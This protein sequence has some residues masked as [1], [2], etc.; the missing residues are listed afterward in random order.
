MSFSVRFVT[1]EHYQSYILL[2]EIKDLHRV[3]PEC[4]ML[5]RLSR[6]PIHAVQNP[7]AP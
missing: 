5:W 4:P 3:R 2:T 6:Q 1:I 7:E